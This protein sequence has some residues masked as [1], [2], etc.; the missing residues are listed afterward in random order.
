[1]NNEPTVRIT[2]DNYGNL[3]L[4]VDNF[5][6]NLTE[7][8]DDTRHVFNKRTGKISK[9]T[10]K[11]KFSKIENDEENLLIRVS[12]Q[13]NPED[14]LEETIDINV[15]AQYII[16]SREE[17]SSPLNGMDFYTYLGTLSDRLLDE[18]RQDYLFISDV[19]RNSNSVI[20]RNDSPVMVVK[21]THEKGDYGLYILRAA[22]GP[23]I[24]PEDVLKADIFMDFNIEDDPKFKSDPLWYTPYPSAEDIL[25]GYVE[26][27][28]EDGTYSGNYSNEK[29][30]FYILIYSP[31]LKD[32]VIKFNCEMSGL[33][34][35]KLNIEIL[36]DYR[37][38]KEFVFSHYDN[39]NEIFDKF[40]SVNSSSGIIDD[41]DDFLD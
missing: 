39:V 1:M 36:D 24:D 5:L 27:L 16:N 19:L 34:F 7:L 2:F 17:G 33:V 41:L 15:L 40:I 30:N 9:F 11:Y 22:V 38:T 13:D 12:C 31:L 14:Y 29:A 26:T 32:K 35:Q 28:N 4:E 10:T 3:S 18:K 8:F 6:N 25:T 20:F 37:T 21:D 23:D